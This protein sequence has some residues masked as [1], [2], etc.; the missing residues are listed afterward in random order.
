VVN[1]AIAEAK[2]AIWDTL[3]FVGE[4]HDVHRMLRGNFEG[5]MNFAQRAALFARRFSR[6]KREAAKLFSSKWL[7]YR[8]GWM[9]LIRDL[10]SAVKALES[11]LEKGDLL[12]G[13]GTA[14]TSLDDTDAVTTTSGPTT[15]TTVCTLTGSRIYRGKAYA[16]VRSPEF[17]KFGADPIV[18]GWELIPFSFV[19]DWFIDVNTFL[20]AASP[21]SGAEM[22]GS[23]ASVRDSYTLE[24]KT[25]VLWSGTESGSDVGRMTRF[26]V[27]SYTRFPHSVSL[28][29]WNPRLTKVRLLDLAALI[30]QRRGEVLRLLR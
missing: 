8:Y 23:M 15:I 2:D 25:D 6:N 12:T 18:T 22:L 10:E 20:Q 30:Y 9:P 28:P 3:T 17:A 26:D 29:S 19:V 4:F 14:T 5:V 13:K 1:S 7:E 16:S 24:Q 27:E 21:F 11:G